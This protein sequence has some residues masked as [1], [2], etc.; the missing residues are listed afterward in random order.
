[1]SRIPLPERG[2]PLDLSYMYSIVE[3]I[4]SLASESAA[5]TQKNNFVLKGITGNRQ[6]QKILNSQVIASYF[7]I[8]QATAVTAGTLRTEKIIFDPVFSAP[9]IVTATIV[10]TSN[11]TSSTNTTVTVSNVTA[12]GCTLNI[13]FNSAGQASLGVNVI[14][15]GLPRNF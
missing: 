13:R 15:V 1:M 11:T 9:P 10:N 12:S 3:A 14:A 6:T 2:Q 4:N 5:I 8:V 7:D